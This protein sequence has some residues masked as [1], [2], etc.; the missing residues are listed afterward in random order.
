MDCVLY[1]EKWRRHDSELFFVLVY[2]QKTVSQTCKQ[3]CKD[4]FFQSFSFTF[5]H[6]QSEFSVMLCSFSAAILKVEQCLYKSRRKRHPNEITDY[7][8]CTVHAH[9]WMS[10]IFCQYV[11][12]R[13]IRKNAKL[14]MAMNHKH[15]C[16]CESASSIV[17]R[18][19]P[20]AHLNVAHGG[21]Y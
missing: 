13:T 3:Q 20:K 16:L 18:A 15:E 11:P 4:F 5:S 8:M 10:C 14:I 12:A 17:E 9:A 6:L 7:H 2:L 19:S 21:N 1:G